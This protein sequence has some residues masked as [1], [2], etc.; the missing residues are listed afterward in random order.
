MKKGGCG[1]AKTI[2]GLNFEKKSR[3]I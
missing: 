1:G 3:S 2:T